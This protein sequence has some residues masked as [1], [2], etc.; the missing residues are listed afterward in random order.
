MGDTDWHMVADDTIPEDNDY[1][2]P[3]GYD[4]GIDIIDIEEDIILTAAEL[5]IWR[6]ENG[7]SADEGECHYCDAHYCHTGMPVLPNEDPICYRGNYQ[8]QYYTNCGKFNNGGD[9]TTSGMNRSVKF[10]TTMAV[11]PDDPL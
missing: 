3:S 1:G 10:V 2:Y 4:D 6:D 11:P 7:I 9:E 5:E 8:C